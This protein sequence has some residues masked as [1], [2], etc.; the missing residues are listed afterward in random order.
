MDAHVRRGWDIA[1]LAGDL[2]CFLIFAGIG[3]RSHEDGI[4]ASSVARVMLPFQLGWLLVAV[5]LFLGRRET[6]RSVSPPAVLAMW[7]PA[8]AI[9]IA[10]RTLVFGRG[11]SPVFAL[12]AFVTNFVLLL[13]WR[14]QVAPRLSRRAVKANLL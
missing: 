7:L 2:A 14:C 12:I 3:L 10:I 5:A 1:L 11:L 4:T 8:W 9:G 6:V 13:L